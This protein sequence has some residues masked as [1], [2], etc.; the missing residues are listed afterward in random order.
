MLDIIKM[1]R[2]ILN[3]LTN[4]KMIKIRCIKGLKSI[5]G[6]PEVDQVVKVR[7]VLYKL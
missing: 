4:K 5:K 3:K 6:I 1:V 2:L 7:R